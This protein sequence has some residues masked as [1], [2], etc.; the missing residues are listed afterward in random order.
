MYTL[1]IEE[2]EEPEIKLLT[3]LKHRKSKGIPEKNICF[4]DSTKAFVWVT[5]NYGKFL[6]RW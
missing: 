5:T 3:S 1:D 6:K 2:A 4:I